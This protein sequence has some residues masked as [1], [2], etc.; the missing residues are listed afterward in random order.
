MQLGGEALD[1]AG[2]LRVGFEFQLLF[3]EVVVGLDLLECRL[4]VLADQ[5]EGGEED[6]FQRDDQRQ[7]RPWAFSMNSIQMVNRATCR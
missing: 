1:L 4:P 2:Q 5:D 3:V 7:C 6:C